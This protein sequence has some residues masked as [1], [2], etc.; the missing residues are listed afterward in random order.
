[1][2]HLDRWRA[3]IREPDLARHTAAYP[4]DDERRERTARW[5]YPHVF[6]HWRFHLTLSIRLPAQWLAL[7]RHIEQLAREH[8]ASALSTPLTCNELALF[9]EPAPGADLILLQRFAMR[10]SAP[11]R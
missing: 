2:T 3:P 11:P 4:L 6:S 9:V 10:S 7:R 5:G 8:F 1:V